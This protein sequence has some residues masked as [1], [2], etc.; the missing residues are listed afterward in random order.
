MKHQLPQLPYPYDSLEPYIDE[1]T[2]E[3]HHT[4]HHQT[5]VDKLNSALESLPQ[6]AELSLED[7]L[8]NLDNI[9]EKSRQA[10]KNHGGGVY[11]HNLFWLCM[12]PDPQVL[13]NN[14][15]AD[16]IDDTFGSFAEFKAKFTDVAMKHFG[17]GWVWLVK[18]PSGDLEIL[19]TKNQDTPISEGNTVLIGLDLW[20]H[21]YY[22]KYQNLRA[23]YIENWWHIADWTYAQ[24]HA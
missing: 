9:P 7:L 14:A 13:P 22:L 23:E 24:T 18:K 19:T 3:V 2:M 20:E 10:I 5:Y 4:K 12:S 15:L 1:K 11:N 8:K 17:S 6:F 21:A 16:K